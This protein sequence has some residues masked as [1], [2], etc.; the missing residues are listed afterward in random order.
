MRKNERKEK[1]MMIRRNHTM[2]TIM[3]AIGVVS[4][5]GKVLGFAL[6]CF[7]IS[8]ALFLVKEDWFK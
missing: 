8:A 6:I 2:A 7:G 1:E 3:L 4:L 5:I